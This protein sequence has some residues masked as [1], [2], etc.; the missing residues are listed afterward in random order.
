MKKSKIC[1]IAGK[2]FRYNYEQGVVEYIAKADKEMLADEVLWKAKRHSS[3]Y[4]IDESGY[5]VIASI[6]LSVEN[7]RSKEARVEYLTGWA[8]ELDEES[9]CLAADFIKYELN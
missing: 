3:L 7:W 6:G 9:A 2:L 1:K 8:D 4:D 5:T